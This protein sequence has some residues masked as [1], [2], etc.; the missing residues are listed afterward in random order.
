LAGLSVDAAAGVAAFGC[1]EFVDAAALVP[2]GDIVMSVAD[3]PVALEA[4]VPALSGAGVAAAAGFDAGA[5][6]GSAANAAPAAPTVDM[7]N[8]ANVL[9]SL[10]FIPSLLKK[11]G[12][13]SAAWSL[14]RCKEPACAK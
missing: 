2:R 5:E 12:Q 6:G 10:R 7:I 8:A 11:G 13:R 9:L 4:G 1:A 14:R 3:A